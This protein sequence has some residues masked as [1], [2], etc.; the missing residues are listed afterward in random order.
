[1]TRT[2]SQ[3]GSGQSKPTPA[4]LAIPVLQDGMLDDMP[5]PV[6]NR[7]HQSVVDLGRGDAMVFAASTATGSAGLSVHARIS[8]PAAATVLDTLATERKQ[9]SGEP[10]PGHWSV[11]EEQLHYS[12]LV[13]DE[14]LA[15]L[16][17]P[18]AVEL[19]VVTLRRRA[20][21]VIAHVLRLV[22]DAERART[23]D[24]A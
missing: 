9:Q 1:M 17:D 10:Q 18:A 19:A 3:T 8:T 6:E 11:T 2:A 14:T 23:G 15:S 7:P 4:Q 5:W 12:E 20:A 22:Q 16:P 24:E 21:A 13:G